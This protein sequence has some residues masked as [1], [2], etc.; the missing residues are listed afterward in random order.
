MTNSTLIQAPAPPLRFIIIGAGLSGIM[1]AIK[2]EQAGF[3]DIT[4]FEKASRPGGTWR[5]NSYPGIACDIPSHF[6]S[7]SFAPNPDWSSR[8]APGGEI[9]AYVESVMRRFDVEKRIC[10]NEEVVR[11]E[12]NDGE[13]RVTTRSGRS[14][15]ANVIIAATGVTH[16]PNYPEIA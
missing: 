1:A 11:C 6:Y 12:Y 5:D 7:Y 14:E 4:I 13:W 9:Q 2:L 15:R 3:T 8:Y 16:H 10:F